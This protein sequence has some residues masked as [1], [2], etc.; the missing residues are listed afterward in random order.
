[1]LAALLKEQ[2]LTQHQQLEKLLVSQIKSVGSRDDYVNLLQ[3]F[4]TYFGGL[5]DLINRYISTAQL[6]DHEQRRK[7]AALAN[8]IKAFGAQPAAKAAVK[9][10]PQINNVGT[11]LGALY[12]IEGSTLGGSIISK[13]ISGRIG[14]DK[15]LSFFNGYGETGMQMW[16]IFK[17]VLNRRPADEEAVIVKAANDTFL[18]FEKWVNK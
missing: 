17:D 3:L 15:G 7:T 10:L 6:P 12:V 16:G 18:Y 2:T 9:D 14:I 8:D 1:M 11:A 5:E 4:Y 13:M